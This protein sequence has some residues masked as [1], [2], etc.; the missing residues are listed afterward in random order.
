MRPRAQLMRRG[1]AGAQAGDQAHKHHPT[2]VPDTERPR[3]RTFPP[4]YPSKK[5][6]GWR[7]SAA[8]DA[9][10]GAHCPRA[11]RPQS[12]PARRQQSPLETTALNEGS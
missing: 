1:A 8:G 4:G 5:P 2:F 10:A 11:A 7:R 9:E 3:A 6:Q 12:R